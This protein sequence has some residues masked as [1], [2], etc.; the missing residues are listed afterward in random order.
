MNSNCKQGAVQRVIGEN[1][2]T[3]RVGNISAQEAAR[4]L[5][6]SLRELKELRRRRVIAFYRL[7]HRTVTYNPNEL[8]AF[9]EKCRVAPAGEAI[10]CRSRRFLT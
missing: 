2:M 9:L 8:E 1:W 4:F 7:G 6:V 10:G 3:G 5:G